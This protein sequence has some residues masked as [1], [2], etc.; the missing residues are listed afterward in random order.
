MLETMLKEYEHSMNQKLMTSTEPRSTIFTPSSIGQFN[1]NDLSG[2]LSPNSFNF[3]GDKTLSV[4]R[5]TI[6]HIENAPLNEEH[7]PD[8]LIAFE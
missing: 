4:G 6:E 7:I 2:S 1:S 3:G 8:K 5:N